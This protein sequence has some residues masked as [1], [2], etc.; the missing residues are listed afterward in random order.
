MAEGG[1]QG[2]EIQP[3]PADRR[4]C[5]GHFRVL[6]EWIDRATA[7]HPQA[8][9]DPDDANHGSRNKRR[10]K[11]GV[12]DAAMVLQLFDRTGEGPEDV[13]VGRLGCQHGGKRSVGRLAVQ[14]GAT[15]AGSGKEMG[16][17]F[18]DSL[19]SIVS[20][21]LTGPVASYNP[22]HGQA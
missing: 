12:S 10:T 7:A 19:N 18:H 13:E 16:D 6:E 2:R 3:A 21:L 9:S 14:A 1:N 4:R 11:K 20:G 5:R 15:D 8:V 22:A 17:R